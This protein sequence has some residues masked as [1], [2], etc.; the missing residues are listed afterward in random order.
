MLVLVGANGL[1]GLQVLRLAE[2]RGIP[3]RPVVR[4]DRDIERIRGLADVQKLCYADPMV[5]S[6]LRAVMEGATTVVSCIDPRTCGPGAPIYDG[7][8]AENIVN[9]ARDAGAHTILHVSVMGAYRW[10]YASLNR[11]SFYLEGGVRNC[12]APWTILRFSCYHD[13]I[14]EG[15][16]APPD[17]GKPVQFKES[18][19]YSPI[20]RVDAAAAILDLLDRI[21]QPGRALALGGPKCWTG[22]E[23]E[24]LVGARR[25][26]GGRKTQYKSLPPGDVSVEP[27]TTRATLGRVP[28]GRLE[29]AIAELDGDADPDPGLAT[30]YPHGD[31]EPH[32]ADRGGEPRVLRECDADL[33][34]T[35]HDQLLRD[36][37]QMGINVASL[38]VD[39]A[40]VKVDFAGAREGKR[41]AR[42]HG[43]SFPDC[44]NVRLLG[45]DGQELHAGAVDWLRDSLADE[46]F[47]WWVR[48]DQAIPEPIWLELDLGVQRRLRDDPHFGPKL[49]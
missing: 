35:V 21:E 36:A 19:R 42:V 25:K 49:Q 4:D 28:Q 6:A 39:G 32:R 29:Q 3:V 26:G 13:E 23:L 12:N 27:E 41:W 18:S 8:A 43:G 48:P 14:I 1:T 38:A 34:W 31:P 15:H 44:V 10:S 2:A 45:P 24:S 7:I 30:V 40:E 9:A 20:S 46:F 47:C 22:P 16:V 17:G 11:R 37:A 5:P 33:R